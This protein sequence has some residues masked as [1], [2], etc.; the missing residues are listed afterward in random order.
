MK[1]LLAHT[2]EINEQLA[3]YGVKFGIYKDGTFNERLFPFDPVPRQIPEKDFAVLEKGLMQR[4]TALNQFIYD[5]YHDKKIV[6]DGVVPEE[7]VYRSPG[8]L[9]QCENITPSKKVYSHISGIDLVEGKDGVWYILEDNLRIPSGASYPLIAR[10]ICRR[11]SPDTF[12]RYHVRDNRDYGAL[13]KRTMDYVNTGG[14][15]VIFTP[16]RYNAAYF[17]HSYLAEQ[18]GAVLAES[19]D[20]FVENQVLYYRTNR[21]P[22]R[23]GALYRRVSDEYM[24]PLC[25]EPSSLIGIPNIMDAYRA[26][27]VAMINAPGNGVADDKGI[28]YFVPKM[29]SYYLG[30]DAILKN[31]PTYLPY[32]EEDRKYTLDNIDKLVIKDVAEAGGYGVVFGENLTAEQ[33]E[34]LKNTIQNAPRRFI[35]QEVIDFKDLPILENGETVERK[36]DLR[37]FVLSGEDVQVWPSGLTRFSR[38]PDSFVVNSSQGGGFKDT[39]IVCQ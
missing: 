2:K 28:Y 10:T 16:G 27:N 8:Y 31:A 21:D 26:G 19:N 11:C 36:A 30:E 20:L 34:D 37:A 17:E 12:K 38:N 9:A 33:R 24:D 39:W 1:T 18:A 25:F 29:I 32:Y 6:K 13:L 7:F 35:A 5:I 14:I 22:V 23:V 3:R 4:V 15:N